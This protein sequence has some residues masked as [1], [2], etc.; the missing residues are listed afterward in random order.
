MKGKHEA[1]LKAEQDAKSEISDALTTLDQQTR[2]RKNNHEDAVKA[3]QGAKEE[4]IAALDTFKQ[5]SKIEAEEAKHARAEADRTSDTTISRLRAQLARSRATNDGLLQ[6]LL[7]VQPTLRTTAGDVII[8]VNLDT[9]VLTQLRDVV[10]A[11]SR[12][13]AGLNTRFRGTVLGS[14]DKN[15]DDDDEVVAEGEG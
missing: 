2:K 3:E 11:R 10:F 4:S 7:Q 14:V 8:E 13:V 12:Q 1:A 9:V 5:Q 15:V 6:Q